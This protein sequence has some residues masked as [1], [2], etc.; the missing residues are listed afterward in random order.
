MLDEDPEPEMGVVGWSESC[1]GRALE[2][3]PASG[4]TPAYPA[5]VDIR[6]AALL[7]A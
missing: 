6:V 1:G 4:D 5:N 2:C 7:V 3:G